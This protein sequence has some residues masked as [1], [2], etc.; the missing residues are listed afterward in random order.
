[1]GLFVSAAFAVAVMTS[2]SAA[3][4][5]TEGYVE[6]DELN[7]QL[8][9]FLDGNRTVLEGDAELCDSFADIITFSDEARNYKGLT[10]KVV[11]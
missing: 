10:C 2:A 7:Q 5:D 6:L 9:E 4:F 1:M 11:R 8:G 3:E